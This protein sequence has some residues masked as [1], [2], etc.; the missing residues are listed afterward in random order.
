MLEGLLKF[1][2]AVDV[3]G[4]LFVIPERL[5]GKS[6]D[7]DYA[8]L[9]ARARAAGHE[10]ALHGY[11]HSRN[12]FGYI[13]PIPLPG[14]E[15]QR[16][17]L[18]AGREYL[19]RSLGERPLGFRAPNYLHNRITFEALA[20]LG[21]KYDSSRTVFK[22]TH[23]IR[24]RFR[25]GFLP[26]VTKVGSIREIA[27][28]GDYGY[29]LKDDAFKPRLER[30]I[31]DLCWVKRIGGTFVVNNHIATW[32]HSGFRFLRALVDA[33]REETDLVTLRELVA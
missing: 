9:L 16:Q 7:E 26:K 31:A 11:R 22:P 18:L 30:A 3:R 14:F 2:D 4:T 28:T 25:T 13:I 21:F 10:I 27:V 20:S 23:G 29:N 17:L 5:S 15:R 12:E 6:A 33:A 32:G 19:K 24:L 1:L 8:G